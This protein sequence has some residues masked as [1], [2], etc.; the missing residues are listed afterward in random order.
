MNGIIG[1]VLMPGQFLFMMALTVGVLSSFIRLMTSAGGFLVVT[2]IFVLLGIVLYF[3]SLIG[4]GSELLELSHLLLKSR[5]R[6]CKTKFMKAFLTSCYPFK[7]KIGPFMTLEKSIM[8]A[9]MA[10]IVEYTVTV[11]L[12]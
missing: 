3:V 4:Q 7:A 9:V 11:L 6:I 1:D 2:C 12:I 5:K 10:T 8:L